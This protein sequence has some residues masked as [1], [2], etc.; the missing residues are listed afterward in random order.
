MTI[1]SHLFLFA[2]CVIVPVLA[3]AL[4]VSV[5]LLEQNRTA[6]QNGAMDRARALMTA[7]DAELIGSTTSLRALATSSA[8]E[9][10]D[11][12]TFHEQAERV[13]LSQPNWR[14]ISLV[15]APDMRSIFH[16]ARP[17]GTVL[18]AIAESSDVER[19]LKTRSPLV[20]NVVTGPLLEVPLIPVRVPVM[21][22]GEV[23]Y[24]LSA[25]VEPQSFEGLILQQ[26]L[27]A[28]WVIA[29]AD[30]NRRFVVRIPSRP[31]GS[32]VAEVFR[33]AML[34]A[35]QGWNRGA[36]V[37]GQDT[38]QAH[39]TSPY[40][41]W[42]V[43]LAIPAGIVD[44]GALRSRWLLTLGAILSILIATLI[45]VVIGRRI[46][47]PIIGLAASARA[48][49]GG[50]PPPAQ[51]PLVREL[52]AVVSALEEAGNAVR[53][54]QRLVEREKQA[55]M[56]S[57][58]AKDQFI[59][60]LSHELRNPLSALTA[61]AHLLN[62]PGVNAKASEHARGVI[63][64]QTRH[65]TRL[66]EDLLDINRVV[67]GKATLIHEVLDLA[68]VAGEVER[69][70]RGSGRFANHTV[71]LDT[72]SAI[73]EADRSRVEQ[74]FTNLLENALK[75]TPSGGKIDIVVRQE[76]GEAVLRINDDGVGIE[77]EMIE[78]VFELFVQGPQALDRL[79]GGL[80]VG[81]ALVKGL[82]ELH[83]GTVSISSG[84]H[85]R[86]ASFSVH[87][88]LA[89]ARS[90]PLAAQ[91]PVSSNAQ[92][93]RNILIVEDNEDA[94]EMLRVMLD[95]AGHQV[96]DAGNAADA[97]RMAAGEVPDVMILDIGLPDMDGYELAARVRESAWGEGVLLIALTG[98]GQAED[99][100]RALE[101]G[102]D[103]HATKP[104]LPEQIEALIESAGRAMESKAG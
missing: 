94:R 51:F 78:R 28:G 2:L 70:W 55:L 56:E 21:K 93:S 91:G 96:R 20:G 87:F 33:T 54:R 32:P 82:V 47:G 95:V 52:A 39:F 66:I 4:Y 24:I 6:I 49:G 46:V 12:R 63:G 26:N 89:E 5:Q 30:G 60:M 29:I 92:T 13:R 18:P 81:L 84:G 15:T 99:K 35:A 97:L 102:F 40:S 19:M 86:G 8:L 90:F 10:G 25:S 50:A 41:G 7:V 75:F 45:A 27:P 43:G 16:S 80:G 38:Y 31:A 17:F 58:V 79:S 67:M 48:I 72:S 64:R 3:F 62:L 104:V 59:A 73:I 74:I 100:R 11:L 76:G 85:E 65:M 44:A 37:E 14:S 68:E 9:V 61:A 88:P 57:D 23:A 98:Y 53:D 77:P 101:A 22:N 71:G 34:G 83:G 42:T 103:A 1:R 69:T 36:T